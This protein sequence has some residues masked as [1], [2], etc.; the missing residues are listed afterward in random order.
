MKFDLIIKEDLK[1]LEDFEFEIYEEDSLTEVLSVIENVIYDTEK[2]DF[3]F[4][5]LDEEWNVTVFG[6]LSVFL[7]QLTDI[8]ELIFEKTDKYILDF[9]KVG[10]DR[11]LLLSKVNSDIKIENYSKETWNSPIEYDLINSKELTDNIILF[12]K[13][14]NTI[15]ESVCPG[16]NRIKLIMEWYKKFKI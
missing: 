5:S 6:D 4:K 13:K 12:V 1:K 11:K 15:V 3:Y 2:I 10:T 9:Y 8:M 7:E 14:I 16:V